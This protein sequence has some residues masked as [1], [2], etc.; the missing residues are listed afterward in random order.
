MLHRQTR[1]EATNLE[2]VLD[3]IDT[4]FESSQVHGL[5]PAKQFICGICFEIRIHLWMSIT[6]VSRETRLK[7]H[8]KFVNEK[9]FEIH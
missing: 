7:K 3:F 5:L 9:H 8:T 2:F 6:V 4:V 1:T